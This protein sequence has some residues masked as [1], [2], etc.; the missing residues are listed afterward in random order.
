MA[1]IG[2]PRRPSD[3]TQSGG[4]VVPLRPREREARPPGAPGVAAPSAPATAER[5]AAT[6]PAEAQPASRGELSARRGLDLTGGL[7][8]DAR[9]APES[10]D[11]TRGAPV[12][13]RLAAFGIKGADRTPIKSAGSDAARVRETPL[14]KIFEGSAVVESARGLQ[15]LDGVVRI[16][17]DLTLQES[18]ARSPDL[19]ALQS[20]VEVGGRLTIEGNHALALLDA[21][22]SLER[23]RGIYLGFNAA[24]QRAAF[25]KLKELDA[26]LIVE[27][28][29]ALTELALPAFERGRLY[30]HIHDNA[31]LTSLALPSLRSIEGELSLVDNPRLKQVRVATKERPADVRGLELRDNGAAALSGLHVRTR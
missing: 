22:H 17:G 2:G 10:Q 7:A 31:A 26:A 29:A 5:P 1:N 24:L 9:P 19:L 23:A 28:N 16:T 27:G 13:A 12:R 25:P 30:L 11:G 20:L 14:G 3:P 15:R 6:E 8:L 18:A 21:L 4:K